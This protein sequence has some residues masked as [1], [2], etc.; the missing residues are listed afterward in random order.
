MTIIRVLTGLYP[1]PF[2][3]S[4]VG[5]TDDAKT[6]P[7]SLLRSRNQNQNENDTSTVGWLDG[8]IDLSWWRHQIET[9]YTLV[10]LCAGNSPITD[11]FPSQRP[12]T[13]SFDV[14]F[15]LR[16][17]KRLSKQSWC[18][19]FEMPSQSLWRH[20]NVDVVSIKYRPMW[21]AT[22]TE[23]QLL[24]KTTLPKR[25][26]HGTQMMLGAAGVLK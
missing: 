17:N 18:W 3:A 24:L 13:R 7:T 10:I 1:I 19:I 8:W 11:E 2:W 20:C 9:F 5:T 22:T 6:N 15:D 14:F 21:E 25:L 12:L 16:L 23:A 26:P 4:S